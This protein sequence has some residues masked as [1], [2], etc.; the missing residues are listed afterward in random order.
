MKR[1]AFVLLV[2][3]A[4][5]LAAALF[6]G[7][8]HSRTSGGGDA[9]TPV[10]AELFTSEGCSSCPPADLLLQ[11]FDAQPIPG[12]QLIVLSEHVDYWNHIGWTDPYSSSAYS[13][14][15]SAYGKR[16]Q[17]DSVYTPQLVVDGSNEVVG[18]DSSQARKAFNQAVTAEKVPIRISAAILESNVVKA[19]VET[20][21]LPARPGKADI[22][23]VVALN[24]AESQVAGGENSGRRLTHVAVVRSLTK[25][26]SIDA[27]QS[28]AQDVSVKIEKGIDPAEL[29]VIAFLQ[30]PGPG[31]I[32]G[33]SRE[34]LSH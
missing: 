1:S 28:F 6:G 15:Q 2:L 14:R 29:R 17:L 26:G 21:P 30:E 12:A 13:E 11:K 16:F 4:L 18:S 20:G 23:F 22:V 27:G 19:H 9:R 24:H 7:D 25:V 34:K 31:K 8:T 32:L 5:F 33:A 3:A 10:V